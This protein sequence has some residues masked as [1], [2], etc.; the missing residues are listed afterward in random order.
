MALSNAEKKRRSRATK[1]AEYHELE[2]ETS[3]KR[4]AIR[5]AKNKA[6]KRA[7][8][9]KSLLSQE[10]KKE[11]EKHAAKQKQ[12]LIS[13]WFNYHN[14]RFD[15]KMISDTKV[16]NSFMTKV[17]IH[18]LDL[19]VA[20]FEISIIENRDDNHDDNIGDDFEFL[21]AFRL[22]GQGGQIAKDVPR[23]EPT[24]TQIFLDDH[25]ELTSDEFDDFIKNEIAL[26]VSDIEETPSNTRVQ[27]EPDITG[28][29]QDQSPNSG[30]AGFLGLEKEQNTTYQ[31]APSILSSY[32]DQSLNSSAPNV[33]SINENQSANLGAPDLADMQLFHSCVDSVLETDEDVILRM[34]M[35]AFDIELNGLGGDTECF[36]ADAFVW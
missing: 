33:P 9:L 18:K 20:E 14:L 2:R 16:L 36:Q 28:V 11:I 19:R 1:G 24:Q 21:N 25:G 15:P 5:R 22:E 8:Q 27:D 3:R 26:F 10:D 31:G 32:E 6:Q 23:I 30:A 13:D 35:E 17:E 34:D 7:S 29:S 12:L 4:M